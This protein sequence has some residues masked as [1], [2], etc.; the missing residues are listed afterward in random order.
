MLTARPAKDS[1][2]GAAPAVPA[3]VALAAA[4]IVAAATGAA[5][6]ART[7]RPPPRAPIGLE[8]AN[9]D[10]KVSGAIAFPSSTYE[11]VVR[12]DLP[13]GGQRVVCVRL[14]AQAAGTLQVTLYRN[15][16]LETPGEAILSF[17]HAVAADDLSDGRDN[18]WAVADLASAP[19]VDGAVW[20]GVRKLGGEP[21]I[22]ASNATA[23]Q[24]FIRDR[25]PARAMGLLP[26]R[27]SPM[28]RLELA[29]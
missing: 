4:L 20:I 23:G 28:I 24:A 10:G 13:A 22:W 7:Q 1:V 6:C 3:P 29:R 11:S 15:S 2:A 5:G 26:V 8:V 16:V 17:Q 19:E 14:L 25:D 27:R 12:F 18:R 21:T 9:D